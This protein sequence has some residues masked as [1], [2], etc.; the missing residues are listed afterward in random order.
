[1]IKAGPQS[2]TPHIKAGYKSNINGIQESENEKLKEPSNIN[3]TKKTSKETRE[4]A[5]TIRNRRRCALQ[6]SILPNLVAILQENT[7]L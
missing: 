1:M 4:T 3:G 5:K 6:E 7:G 2:P